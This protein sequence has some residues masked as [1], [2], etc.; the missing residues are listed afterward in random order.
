MHT[1]AVLART[2]KHDRIRRYLYLSRED[3]EVM[4]GRGAVVCEEVVDELSGET[5]FKIL[6]SVAKKKRKQ[7]K[8]SNF[9]GTS[10]LVFV[11]AFLR[12]PSVSSIG[13]QEAEADRGDGRDILL[14]RVVLLCNIYSQLSTTT[15]W[16][17][18]V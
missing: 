6:V 12:L 13:L 8:K 3:Y 4:K 17:G 14:F 5:R 1:A 2:H 15:P 9:P 18:F 10:P 7:M 16:S 11:A